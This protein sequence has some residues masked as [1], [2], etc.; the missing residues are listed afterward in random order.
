MPTCLLR[1]ALD[2]ARTNAHIDNK[3]VSYTTCPYAYH[4]PR[5]HDFQSNDQPFGIP[6][7]PP[8]LVVTLGSDGN[9]CLRTDKSRLEGGPQ[10]LKQQP[11]SLPA[12]NQSTNLHRIY[13]IDGRHRACQPAQ[14]TPNLPS[15]QPV[16]NQPANLH[17]IY[18]L[19]SLHR[20]SQP[21]YIKST[22]NLPAGQPA[23]LHRIYL[24]A[25][26]HR[27]SQPAS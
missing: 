18:Q 1:P 25:S 24:L 23:N 2:T 6:L 7:H 13:Q 20:I 9:G 22:S 16:S 5:C 19:A 21:I 8:Q 12:S 11:V 27:T 14:P 17:Q 10:R 26:L 15:G 3:Q 4:F